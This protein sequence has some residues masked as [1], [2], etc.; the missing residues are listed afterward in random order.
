VLAVSNFVCAG[1]EL[2]E[3]LSFAVK[4]EVT[5]FVLPSSGTNAI[6]KSRYTVD[7]FCA[8]HNWQIE[9]RF[10]GAAYS[11]TQ[12]P[13]MT[14]TGTVQTCKRIADGVR[15]YTRFQKPEKVDD[16]D[17][18]GVFET[19]SAMP[20][21]FPPIEE[22]DLFLTWLSLCPSPELPV[23]GEGKIKRLLGTPLLDNPKNQGTYRAKYLGE[24]RLFLAD[25]TIDNDGVRFKPDG[26]S[27]QFS[28][29]FENGFQEFTFRVTETTNFD[30][31][32]FPAASEMKRFAPMPRPKS[33]EHV[34]SVVLGRFRLL[35]IGRAEKPE[36]LLPTRFV[37]L[38]TRSPV[39]KKGVTANYM[40][41]NDEWLALTNDRMKQLV[42]V[43]AQEKA[44]PDD[45][46]DYPDRISPSM[47]RTRQWA[48]RLLI[49]FSAVVPVGLCGF[50]FW[51][52]HK[53][54]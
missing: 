36:S 31:H 5:I 7:F 23:M 46:R 54:K 30:G 22:F 28:K 27:F 51:S 45:S 44:R 21:T 14:Q 18:K 48:I 9:S 17:N 50:Y 47:G 34:Y 52:K 40:V 19:A 20:L 25:L 24:E 10:E 4:G 39:L 29:P 37:A 6:S 15:L 43:V 53:Q 38:D 8:N 32:I 16:A 33:R 11:A 12:P 35:S 13:I 3:V 49:C 1:G 26:S 42:K 2:S 41:T